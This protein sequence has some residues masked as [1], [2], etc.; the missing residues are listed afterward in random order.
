MLT[1][2]A[3]IRLGSALV[4]LGVAL[5]AFGAHGLEAILEENKRVETWNTAVLYHL[6]H[7]MG[8]LF[9]SLFRVPPRGVWICFTLGI[10]IF[11]GSLYVLALTNFT[12]LGMITPVG[13]LAFLLG[14]LTLF[15]AAG[16]L[17]KR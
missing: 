11:S 2:S 12:K 7:G 3:I 16:A 9:V 8:L 14:W 4:F 17:V 5:G 10:L 6:I 13:G 15:L 1:Q